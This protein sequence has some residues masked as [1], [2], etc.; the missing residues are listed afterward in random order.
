MSVAP[1]VEAA[2]PNLNVEGGLGGSADWRTCVPFTST[3]I[4]GF[5]ALGASSLIST[6]CLTPAAVRALAAPTASAPGALAAEM[7]Q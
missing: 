7:K 1:P 6:A 3:V 5:G 4:C 2:K